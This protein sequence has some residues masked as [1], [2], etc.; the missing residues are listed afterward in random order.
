MKG[1]RKGLMI[2][3][4]IGLVMIALA[5]FLLPFSDM[6][7]Q[8]VS[9]QTGFITGSSSDN[10]RFW[11]GIGSPTDLVISQT[12][13]VGGNQFGDENVKYSTSVNAPVE[14]KVI[15][16]KEQVFQPQIS[17][18]PHNS[19][20]GIGTDH[21]WKDYVSQTW[22]YEYM[23]WPT[24]ETATYYRVSE[25]TTVNEMG[26]TLFDYYKDYKNGLSGK[27]SNDMII[28]TEGDNG[29][30]FV[31]MVEECASAEGWIKYSGG[32]VIPLWQ[33]GNFVQ[34][35][36]MITVTHID[37]WFQAAREG[38][39]TAKDLDL[40]LYT[41]HKYNFNYVEKMNAPTV[42][43]ESGFSL[44]G[45]VPEDESIILTNSLPSDVAKAQ[46]FL[47]D[48][49]VTD[50]SRVAWTDYTRAFSPKGMNY[51]Y[52][53][54][55]SVDSSGAYADSDAEEYP[56]TY[57]SGSSAIV[58]STPKN[59]SGVD[60]GDGIA[61]SVGGAQGASD[62]F[63]AVDAEEAP[64]LTRVSYE[65]R[66][67][68]NLD[69]RSENGNYVKLDGKAYLK[70]NNIWYRSSNAGLEKFSGT[71][72]ASAQLRV[73]N[74]MSIHVLA[75]EEGKEKGDFQL[76]HYPY[77]MGQQTAMP[78]ATVT[79]SASEPAKVKMGD[80]IGLTCS[81]SGSKIFYTTNGKA[82]V[83]KIT[84][85]GPV[86]GEGTK[87]YN[88]SEQIVVNETFANYGK[89]FLV[90]AQ[91]VTY[92][93][94][95]DNYYQVYQNS[96]VGRYT[97]MVDG[98]AAVEVVQAVPQTN[99][100]TPT[101][102]QVGSRIQLY[103]ETEGVEIYYTLDGSEP[104]FD[105]N[106][107]E[108]GEKTYK[109]SNIAGII[110]E[111]NTDSSFFTITA[112]AYKPGLADSDI[113][114]LVYAY[115]GAVSSPYANPI[116]GVVE[117]NTE[118]VLKTA[119]EGAVIYYEI[120]HGDEVPNTPSASS[121][122]FDETNPI[123]ITK[124]TTVKAYAVKDSMESIV[125]TF[126]YELAQKLEMPKPS[127][128]TGAV[129]AS[130]TVISLSAEEDAIIHYTLDGSDP[131][132]AK[133]KKVLV[134]NK[135]VLNGKVGDMIILR[136][137][138]T[139]TGYSSS[140]VCTYSYAISTYAGG[141]F[142]DKESGS[143]VKNGE[144][145]HL[146]TD[147]SNAQIYY[148]MDGAAPTEDSL[149][150]TSIVI[151][152]E[153]GSQV[154]ITAMAIA[155]GSEKTTAFATFTYT[156]MNKLAAPTASIP[157]KA[158]FTQEGEV[159]LKAETGSIYYTTDGSEPTAASN[160][161]MKSIVVDK[162]MTIK[163]IAI[164]SEYQQS[165]VS[166]FTYDFSNQVAP[167]TANYASGEMEMGTQVIF[168]TATE[169]ATIYYRTDGVEPD[170][171]K[172]DGLQ[173]YTGPIEVTRATNFKVIAVKKHMS[174][175]RILSVGY[176]VREPVVIE[177]SAEEEEQITENGSG[178]LQ[179]RRSFSDT[180][181]GPSYTDIVLR[182]AI[183][184]VVVSG[185]EGS[186]REDAVLKVENMQVSDSTEQ[187]V[188]SVLADSYGVIAS[189][190]VQMVAADEE[191]QPEEE[192]EIGIPIPAEYQNSIIHL[193]KVQEDGYMK[194]CNTRRSG[195]VAYVMT[196]DLGNYSIA[197]PVELEQ[198]A[199]HNSKMLIAYGTIVALLGAGGLLIRMA[200]KKKKEGEE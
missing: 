134:G 173:V 100:D 24:R 102:I 56:I 136:A 75:V 91:A 197:A 74:F 149:S 165:D 72:T 53:R 12:V 155:E 193:V 179:S 27:W 125:A 135:V 42:T 82:P 50:F 23:N 20:T 156:I 95:D 76:L 101:E 6:V 148:T 129:V 180:E 46:Y 108:P 127:V 171:N 169:D 150:G 18:E 147:M 186:L 126:R 144:I 35:I 137:Y 97:Y 26:Q 29:R 177:T 154:T 139:K 41:T 66:K 54:N 51:L 31:P 43:T 84:E 192:I 200:I 142:A 168:K 68:L 88:E 49:I 38:K 92:T 160:L 16:T 131:K 198:D 133:N 5:V 138:A 11:N 191:V 2:K 161:Y 158:V 9:L 87:E 7:V 70:I 44:N 13:T 176:T 89:T 36:E 143:T 112:V 170:P 55:R 145:I 110:V 8:A 39:K 194:V 59:G 93:K 115:P 107:G 182:N 189:Y 120:A 37:Y 19:H 4:V 60:V 94:I 183:Y 28:T 40:M 52:V 157:D 64:V 45:G 159:E 98:Q 188:K 30:K 130:G 141:I 17:V 62:I 3:K 103:S 174:D 122:V 196:K 106:T 167:P 33:N 109:Y 80:V 63:Y 71:I 190:N 178:R 119:S 166:T 83:I 116:S 105:T 48:G 90:M 85:D 99:A 172:K 104:V 22:W 152:G 123:R 73:N 184:G 77:G 113:S 10:D 185:E 1:I 181:S 153:P 79:T 58:T 111:R 118:V 67:S 15:N 187:M 96:L 69:V 124:K 78:Q 163:A 140:D 25:K 114:R 164:D 199:K 57:M 195:G 132:D 34:S 86:A 151:D 32:D 47:S 146:H 162:A 61:L 128:G 21:S 65:D 121:K 14:V 81:T 117:E 175:S